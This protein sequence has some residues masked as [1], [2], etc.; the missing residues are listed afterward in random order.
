MGVLITKILGTS[1]FGPYMLAGDRYLLLHFGMRQDPKGV[2]ELK[3]A[4]G[5]EAVIFYEPRREAGNDRAIVFP[6]VMPESQAYRISREL[7]EYGIDLEIAILKT[8]Y[9][10][11]RNNILINNRGGIVNPEMYKRERESVKLL[12]EL[13]DIEI[14]PMSIAGIRLPGSVAVANDRGA[15]IHEDASEEEMEAIKEILKL[16]KIVRGR[17]NGTP[18][19]SVGLVANNRGIVIGQDSSP[20]DI[21]IATDVFL[22]K[23]AKYE[24]RDHILSM[25]INNIINRLF[26][27]RYED[28]LPILRL[29]MWLLC[30]SRGREDSHKTPVESSYS[31]RHL[32]S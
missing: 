28:Y 15:F 27:R 32:M 24:F 5:I 11:I 31:R 20:H 12:E 3:E 18:F 29:R 16:E 8:R 9:T 21:M 23:A 7:E 4:L 26:L 1:D 10:A 2:E 6:H 17:I 13:F 30:R 25:G 19:V 22:E 14:I